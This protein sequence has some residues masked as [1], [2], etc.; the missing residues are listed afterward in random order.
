M[1]A[2]LILF[3]IL[4]IITVNFVIERVLDYLNRQNKKHD[5]PEELQGVYDERRYQ[6]SLEY[7]QANDR[8]SAITA[9]FGFA[10]SVVLLLGGFFGWLDIQLRDWITQPIILSLVYFAVL[11]VASDILNLPF[12]LYHTF[13]IE[14]RFGF[15]KMTPRLF[16]IDKLKGYALT[17]V[18]GGLVVGVF[19]YL[20]MELGQSF[21]LYFWGVATAIM[22]LLNVFYTSV[23]VPLFNKLTPLEDGSL[24]NAITA[25]ARKVNFP[26]TNV[27]VIDGSKRSS[28]SNA[29]FSGMGSKKK[30]VLYDTLIEQHSEEELIAIIAHEVGH[31]K[32]K[33]IISGLFLSIAQIGFTLYILS[34]LI[35]NEALSLALGGQQL[36]IHLNL[37]AF[38]ILYSP[39]STLTGLMMNVVSR[40][41]EFE[42]D[43][44]ATQTYGGNP[45]QKALKKLSAHNMSN[46]LPHAW[47]VFFHYSHPPL[48]DRLRAIRRKAIAS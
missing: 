7:Q 4:T 25:Y 17:A 40:K 45:L 31:Y 35:F 11:F 36:S 38:G 32:K 39:I 41:N 48:L 12:Q 20:V 27:Y 14:E 3:I 42:A 19:L 33:H 5:L 1:E 10:V 16:F 15:N 44:Y 34:L 26:I 29:F 46:L 9:T 28:K 37:I 23:F 43:A 47:Y 13:M 8:F 2:Q 18:L 22:I 21:W 6:R 24:K 30:V